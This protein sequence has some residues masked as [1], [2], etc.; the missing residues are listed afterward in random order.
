MVEYI[1]VSVGL[2]ACH[3]VCDGD[4]AGCRLPTKLPTGSIPSL[5]L[6]NSFFFGLCLHL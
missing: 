3:Y 2:A 5:V 6:C 4:D 1:I